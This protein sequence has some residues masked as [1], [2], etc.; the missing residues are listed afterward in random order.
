MMRGRRVRNSALLSALVTAVS[1]AALGVSGPAEAAQSARPAPAIQERD[2]FAS[3]DLRAT[4]NFAL[5]EIGAGNDLFFVPEAS[6]PFL[7]EW[8]QARTTVDGSVVEIFITDGTNRCLALNATTGA[9]YLHAA[10]GCTSNTNDYTQWVFKSVGKNDPQNGYPIYALQN[11]YAVLGDP[12][13]YDNIQSD[14]AIYNTCA[15]YKTNSFEWFDY[16]LPTP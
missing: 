15:P 2:C 9:I 7:P 12:C 10:N 16:I 11:Q 3:F 14:P 8:C 1:L 6:D 13:M 4:D 5:S